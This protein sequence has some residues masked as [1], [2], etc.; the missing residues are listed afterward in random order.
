MEGGTGGRKYRW[1]ELR[2]QMP[3]L[4]PSTLSHLV[5]GNVS[6]LKDPLNAGSVHTLWECGV[7]WKIQKGVEGCNY[8]LNVW[9][10]TPQA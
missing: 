9:L 8:D 7:Q 6:E 3:H 2:I 1:E 5:C 10:F 4:P